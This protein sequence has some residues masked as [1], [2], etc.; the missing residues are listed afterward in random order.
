MGIEAGLRNAALAQRRAKHSGRIR[1]ADVACL[2]TNGRQNPL[3]GG[4]PLGALSGSIAGGDTI[5]L[6]RACGLGK[7]VTQRELRPGIGGRALD[8]GN[9]REDEER[10]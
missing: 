6:A 8:E 4:E 5:G 1:A 2:D 7:C 10:S 9:R 3:E